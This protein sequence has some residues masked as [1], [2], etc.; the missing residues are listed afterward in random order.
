[1]IPPKLIKMASEF[2]VAFLTTVINFS[3]ENIFSTA[4]NLSI[5]N[6]FSPDNEKI[7]TVAP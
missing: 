1:M 2:L 4:I 6:S 7:A 3:I 5:E